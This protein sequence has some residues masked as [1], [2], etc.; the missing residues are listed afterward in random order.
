MSIA[1]Y[2]I[3][4][5]VFKATAPVRKLLSHCLTAIIFIKVNTLSSVI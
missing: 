4:K 3:Q 2:E 1:D 5:T